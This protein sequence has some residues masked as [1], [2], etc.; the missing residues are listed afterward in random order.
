MRLN[1]GI[2]QN[3]YQVLRRLRFRQSREAT[4][5]IYVSFRKELIVYRAKFNLFF[6][7]SNKK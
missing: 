1:I 4:L 6:Y 5:I 3:S 2:T 7:P